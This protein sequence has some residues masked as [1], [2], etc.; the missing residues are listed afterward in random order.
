MTHSSLIRNA[1]PIGSA[2]DY[3]GFGRAAGK[4][5]SGLRHTGP[6][7]RVESQEIGRMSL[8]PLLGEGR[9]RVREEKADPPVHT[10]SWSES[11]LV[12]DHRR[13]ACADAELRWKSG[14]HLI[15]L[16]ETGDSAQT[17]V[18]AE[19]RVLYDGRD[20]PG[21]LTFVPA[22]VERQ[23]SYRGADLSYSALWIDP[24]L[25]EALCTE[26]IAGIPMFVNGS[27]PAISALLKSIRVDIAEHRVPGAAYMEHMAAL[28][29]LRL[30]ALAGETPQLVRGGRLSPRALARV[31]DHIEAHLGADIALSD[32]AR[33][34]GLPCD[35]FA[36]QFKATTGRAPYAYV[37]ERRIRHAESLLADSNEEIGAIAH[38]LGFSSQSH[39]TTA[40]R[41]L[42]GTTPRAY[43]AQF[44]P[45]LR[46]PRREIERL[47]APLPAN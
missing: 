16:T 7:A 9:I 46:K 41:R 23:C 25:Q 10:V 6:H 35:T 15:V 20:R 40:F 47:S 12:F 29:L 21:A 14:H 19:G 1:L 4:H 43:R 31:Q 30:A 27:D 28:I 45:G 32:L 36:R 39:F 3:V 26:T 2:V 37:I 44:P 38:S 33:L 17:L 5:A 22:R 18:R 34:L 8:E 11:R 42:N 24:A 13:W